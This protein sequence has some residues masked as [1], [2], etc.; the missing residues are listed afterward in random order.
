VRAGRCRRLY[1]PAECAEAIIERCSFLLAFRTERFEGRPRSCRNSLVPSTPPGRY[2]PRPRP[3]E[4]A[5]MIPRWLGLGLVG[6]GVAGAAAGQSATTA[7]HV[8]LSERFI[9]LSTPVCR[10]QASM[11]CVDA[12]WR[13]ADTDRDGLLSAA[14][15]EVVRK[16]A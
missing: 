6:Q 5:A 13:Y 14:E 4:D 2:D 16:T 1:G 7:P 15:L 11:R 9:E 10:K 12:G 8:I 3:Y